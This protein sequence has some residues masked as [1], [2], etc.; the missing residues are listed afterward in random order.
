MTEG[1]RGNDRL[2]SVGPFTY[3]ETKPPEVPDDFEPPSDIT[4]ALGDIR[5]WQNWKDKGMTNYGFTGIYAVNQDRL[6]IDNRLAEY[7][8]EAKSGLYT[9][10]DMVRDILTKSSIPRF[11]ELSVP[12]EGG[13]IQMGDMITFTAEIPNPAGGAFIATDR[14]SSDKDLIEKGDSRMT[15]E[16]FYKYVYAL[17]MLDFPDDTITKVEHKLGERLSQI[18]TAERK[19]ELKD[20]Y[21]ELRFAGFDPEV[22]VSPE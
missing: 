1:P 19:F 21:A 2:T 11:P 13:G 12:A 14:L 22:K 7:D 16:Y 9:H 6:I 3:D 4:N 5:W 8:P 20:A 10:D 18:F 17:K 15:P